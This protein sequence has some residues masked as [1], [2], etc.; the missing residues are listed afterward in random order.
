M[1]PVHNEILAQ[2]TWAEEQILA[3]ACPILSIYRKQS[4]MTGY[5]GHVVAY[6]QKIDKLQK[7]L[8]KIGKEFPLIIV[9]VVGNKKDPET[10]FSI[11][12][13]RHE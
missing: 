8:P 5:K 6:P 2:C 7:A 11:V 4:G 1:L 13:Q 9:R 12:A 3:R 10:V